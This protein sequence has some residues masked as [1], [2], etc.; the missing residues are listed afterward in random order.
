[1]EII[2]ANRSNI[3]IDEMVQ[4]KVRLMDDKEVEKKYRVLQEKVNVFRKESIC[5]QF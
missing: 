4:E 3:F 1:M 5:K 2:I